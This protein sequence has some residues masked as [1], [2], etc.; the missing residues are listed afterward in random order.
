VLLDCADAC[1]LVFDHLCHASACTG[2]V[3][4]C[5]A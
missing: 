4:G 1:F 2:T 5:V 3:F